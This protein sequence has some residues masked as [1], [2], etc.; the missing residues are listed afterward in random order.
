VA[1]LYHSI[2]MYVI[3]ARCVHKYIRRAYICTHYY[4]HYYYYYIPSTVFL[5]VCESVYFFTIAVEFAIRR[6]DIIIIKTAIG[7][8]DTRRLLIKNKKIMIIIIPARKPRSVIIIIIMHTHTILLFY[9]TTCTLCVFDVSGTLR[10]V[11]TRNTVNIILYYYIKYTIVMY[12]RMKHSSI[13]ARRRARGFVSR[14][15]Y[16]IIRRRYN[17][18][19][20]A[21]NSI[22][23]Y[24]YIHIWTVIL[25][26]YTIF[27][28][29]YNYYI[30]FTDGTIDMLHRYQLYI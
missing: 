2:Y 30:I 17:I 21:Y 7:E 10:C 27:S 25:Y 23:V 4:Y 22:L 1:Y 28:Y 16:N 13:E 20:T 6:G 24:I 19:S 15:S 12:A 26:T 9:Y 14:P 5:C 29:V 18:F 11:A 8:D 3:Y